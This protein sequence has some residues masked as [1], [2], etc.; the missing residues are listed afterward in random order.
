MTAPSLPP[1]IAKRLADAS[2]A[3]QAGRFD[4]AIAGY[5]WVLKRAPDLPDSWYN[6]G[7]LLR[8]VGDPLGALEAYDR[9]LKRG[10]RQPEEVHL[11]MGVIHADDLLD[12]ERAQASYAA[13]L[14]ANPRYVQARFNL[15]NTL[16]DLGQRDA[17]IAQYSGILAQYPDEPETLARLANA[18]RMATADDPLIARLQRAFSRQDLPPQTRATVGFALGRLLD[19]AAEYDRAFEVYASANR[20]S[21]AGRPDG[22]PAYIPSQHDDYVAELIEQPPPERRRTGPVDTIR[23]VFILGQFRSGSTL[24]EQVLSAHPD[25]T[26]AG[27]LP[28]L[29]SMAR[30]DLAPYPARLADLTEPQATTLRSRYLDGLRQRLPAASGLVTDKRPDNYVH[31]GLI[32][33]LFP[34]ARILHT[35][36]DA[37]DTCLS[38]YFLHLSHDQ[39]HATDLAHLG[40]QYRAYQRLMRHW[41]RIAPDNIHDVDYDAL[42]AAPES[43]VR[44]VLDFLGLPY[45][46]ACLDFQNSRAPVKTA[47]VWQVREP[48]YTRSSG[49]WR[50]YQPHIG[51]LLEALND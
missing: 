51:P 30:H 42:V 11:N 49:R 40:H 2:A 12:P 27:E 17:A 34:D 45:D 31:I 35:V 10:I 32:L 19:Q 44:K 8:R 16:E 1:K 29:S 13:A 22:I 14:A 6:L 3:R 33:R 25:V 9:A 28:L 18:T 46:P 50:N 15:A 39:A 5:R 23:P 41:K 7:W 43:E 36:R 4:D 26:T 48:L 20:L 24:L 37:R 21:S 47:S 38:N